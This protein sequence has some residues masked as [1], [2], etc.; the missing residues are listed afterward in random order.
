MNEDNLDKRRDSS[1][2]IGVGQGTIVEAVR[3]VNEK[4]KEEMP[5]H[6]VEMTVGQ[7]RG[8]LTREVL[9]NL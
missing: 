1:T 4:A 8:I 9:Q 3:V 6:D 2:E 5:A 7:A